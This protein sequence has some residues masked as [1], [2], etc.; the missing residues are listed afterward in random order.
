MSN[1]E[2]T[3]MDDV[4]RVTAYQRIVSEYEALDQEIDAL[5]IKYDGA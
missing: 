3:P 5:I 4:G 2:K 1:Q